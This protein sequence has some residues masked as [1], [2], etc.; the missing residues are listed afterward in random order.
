MRL[1]Q[2]EV[3]HILKAVRAKDTHALVYLYGSRIDENA[4]GGDIDLLIASDK[5]SL[6]DKIELLITIKDSIGEQKID[7]TLMSKDELNTSSF[8]KSIELKQLSER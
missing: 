5:L 7:L 8:F 3:T 4:K 1:S 6:K 2:N